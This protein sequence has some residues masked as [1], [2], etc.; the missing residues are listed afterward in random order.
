VQ[1]STAEVSN[2]VSQEQIENLPL[3][4]RNYQGG[5]ALQPSWPGVVNVKRRYRDGHGRAAR[6]ATRWRSTAW[7]TTATLYTV[8]GVWNMNTGNMAQ[9]TILPNPDQIQEVRTYQ[10][11]FSPKDSLLGRVRRDGHHKERHARSFTARCSSTC[12]TT[13]S[14]ARNF[15]SPNVPALKQNIFGGTLGGPVLFS[16]IQPEP[17]ED[18]LLP[19]SARCDAQ[20]RVP[21]IWGATADRRHAAG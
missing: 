20:Q 1:L 14:T 6:R 7:A 9:T 8:D 21:A 3:N 5:G 13:R 11:N 19:Q 16:A 10:N 4:G 15:F 12:A 2:I 17:R 18:I